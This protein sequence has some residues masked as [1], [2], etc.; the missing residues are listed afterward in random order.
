MSM[1]VPLC[2]R[3]IAKTISCLEFSGLPDFEDSEFA[4]PAFDAE[5][6]LDL[7]TL[8]FCRVGLPLVVAD[9]VLC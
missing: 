6:D 3:S 5:V 8:P 4:D 9:F 1:V 2:A 7:A